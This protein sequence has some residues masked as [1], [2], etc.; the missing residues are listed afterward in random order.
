MTGAEM[1][2]KTA[3]DAGLEICFANPGTTELAL[4]AALDTVK[5]IR[6]VLGLFEGVCTGAADGYGRIKQ[7]PAMTV[8][9]LGPGFANGIANLHNARRARSPVLNIIGEHTTW[10]RPFDPPLNMDIASLACTVSGWQKE[11]TSAD[12]LSSDTARAISASLYGQISTLIVPADYQSETCKTEVV[13]RPSFSFDAIDN[14]IIAQA[15]SVIKQAK[16]PALILGG[17]ALREQGLAAA[18][19]I[20]AK[21]GC[22]LLMITFPAYLESGC[23]FPVLKRIPYF[24]GQARTM[25]SSYDAFI[26]AGAVE[27]V[28]FFGYAAGTT[29]FLPEAAPRLRIDTDQQDAG[30]VLNALADAFGPA[31]PQST[32]R[33][34]LAQY[35]IPPLPEG[36]LNSQKMCAAIACLQPEN[37]IVVEEGVS[38]AA[39]YYAYSPQLKP[40]SHMTLT[41]GA[42]GMGIPLSL[43][44]ALAAPD[45]QVID[46]QAD[47]SALYTLQALWSQAHEKT[48]VITV[49][50]SNRKYF[51]IEL[52]CLRAGYK[53]LGKEAKSLMS[54]TEP[55]LDW[56]SLSRGMGVPAAS[57]NT[58]EAFIHEFQTALSEPG[59]YLIEAIL[60]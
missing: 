57:V 33:P 40:Y 7:K 14:E 60:E 43:G 9:H 19:Q 20:K 5:S 23:G 27:P 36:A 32:L 53:S 6:P 44:A 51:T 42:I 21:T 11:N 12:E 37:C 55:D 13:A 25:L 49:I 56:V 18:A 34:I 15:V 46:I 26:L 30:F 39:F 38:S 47:G 35:A 10:I 2:F 24:P 45:R 29:S 3:A 48:K 41:G 1:I 4:V 16:K 22:D 31:V 28:A 58:A 54:L 50:C 8:L 52:E 17:R 59:P